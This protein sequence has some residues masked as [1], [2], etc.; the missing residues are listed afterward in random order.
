MEN[1]VLYEELGR[2]DNSIIYKGRRK[3]TINFVAIHCIEKCKRPEVTNTVRMTHDIQHINVVKFYEWYETSNHLWLVVELCTGGSLE[4]LISQ[5]KNLPESSV[6]NFGID[7]VTGLHYIHSLGILFCDLRPSK[8][9]LDGP[10]I[11]KYADFGLAKVEGENLEELF[12]KFSDAGETW[13][14]DSQL[15]DRRSRTAGH[16]HYMAPEVLQ[17]GELTLLSDLWSLGCVMYELFTGHPPFLAESYPQ[18][19]DKIANKG[20][21]PP[22]V[23]GTRFSSKPSHDFLSLIDG[24]LQK[25]PDKRLGWPGLVTHPFWEGKLTKL[26]KDLVMSQDVQ[27]SM[28]T[29]ARSSVFVDGTGSV[30]GK[31]KTVELT[32]R[33]TTNL[34]DTESPSRPGTSGGDFLR[35]KTAPTD[36]GGASLFTLSARP[37]TAVPPD[38]S[39]RV[40]SPYRQQHSPLSTREP[41]GTG[42]DTAELSQTKSEILDLIYHPTDFAISSIIDNPKIQRPATAKYDAKTLPVPP[43]SAEK[44]GSLPEKDQT[45]HLKTILDTI[46]VS[47][48]GP[49]SQK[50]IQLYHYLVALCSNTGV[51]TY[52]MKNNAVNVLT[53][54][55]KEVT[56]AEVRVKIARV[57]AVMASNT[58]SLD[59]STKVSEALTGITEIFR[60]NMKNNRIKQGLLPALGELVYL[61]AL[62]EEQQSSSVDN[63]N[64]PSMT[65]AVICRSC[66]DGEDSVINHIAAKIVENV[67]TTKGQIAQKMVTTEMAQSLWFI[68]KHSTLDALRITALSALHRITR[69]NPQVFQSVIDT[70]GLSTLL[71]ALSFGITKIQQS[72]VTMF[73]AL[74]VSGASLNRLTQDKDFLQKILRLLESPSTVIRGKAFV[75]I[76]ELAKNN[77][78]ILLSSCQYRLVMYLERDSR[79]QTPRDTKVDPGEIEYLNRCLDLLINYISDAVPKIMGEVLSALDSVAGRKHPNTVQA[80]QLKSSLPLVH[81][82]LHLVTSQVFRPKIVTEEFV[83]SLGSLLTHVK[84]IEN[85]ETNI[86]A[87]SGVITVSEFVNTVMSVVEGITQ[88]PTLLMDHGSVVME[89]VLPTMAE[90]VV[91]QNGDTRALSL[92]LFSEMATVFLT[93]DAVATNGKV[94]TKRLH[95]I[96]GDKLFPHYEQ[97]LLDQDP[98]PYYGLKLLLALLESNSAFIKQ[99]QQQ[100]LV[101]VIFQVLLDHQNN[102][103]SSAMQSIAGILNCLVSH[104]ET[105]M[106]ELYEQ[107]LIDYFTTIFFEVSAACFEG[108]DNSGVDSKVVLSMLQTLL[109]TLHGL[110]KYVS[111]FVRKALQVGQQA[112]KAGGEGASK[113]T[114][115]AEHLLLQNKALTDLTSLLTQLLTHE[116]GD[117]HDP[118][119]KCLSLLVQLF[120]GEHREALSPENMDYYSKALRK[121]DAKKQ[122]VLL[123]IIKRLVSTDKSH[124]ESMKNNGE[125][126]ANTITS[127]VK[128][129]SSHADVSLSSLAAEILKMTGHLK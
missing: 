10:G 84:R 51:S 8:I 94:D 88:H 83:R 123:R 45:R 58:E 25:D 11:L 79:R 44:F 49:P 120:G 19:V 76:H 7:L 33:Q 82:F 113:E 97:I 9:L 34:Q 24:L 14:T 18:L 124:R 1:F 59:E 104:K 48:K 98:L 99:F 71:S 29:T 52:L 85:G 125:G 114:E 90:L 129:A 60:E 117:I 92:S 78:E 15:D 68:F 42:K 50:R 16:T 77:H 5:D 109:E 62:Q 118:A 110:L 2:G 91:S 70:V 72:I 73:G 53:R 3:G 54:Q 27:G 100:G 64:I 39:L 41:L 40:N 21:A 106:K 61:V 89:T 74:I 127:L 121:A 108:E 30:L 96:I 95:I 116:D 23:K 12:Q 111:D 38:D 6:R 32:D 105:N 122:K 101:S 128:T 26:A 31:V 46:S 4:Y 13:A 102:P 22:K 57:I 87:S 28:A 81:I 119:C 115:D 43:I 80:K 126:L 103:L 63:W 17:G 37:H 56:H 93:Q 86:E 75:V 66:R 69:H 36:D 55:L 107:G 20:Y 65:F 67:A 47:E 35:P 112:K